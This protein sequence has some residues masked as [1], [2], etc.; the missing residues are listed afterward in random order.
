MNNL[1][2]TIFYNLHKFLIRADNNEYGEL[3]EVEDTL[4]EIANSI[5]QLSAEDQQLFKSLLK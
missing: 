4:Y 5:N 3:P 2:H 1:K